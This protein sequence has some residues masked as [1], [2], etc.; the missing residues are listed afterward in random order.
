MGS[1][2][3][4][5][6]CG[7]GQSCRMH[8]RP[9]AGHP[10]HP[11]SDPPACPPTAPGRPLVPPLPPRPSRGDGHP[12][13][14]GARVVQEQGWGGLQA[15]LA[16]PALATC[17]NEAR[18][19]SR[20]RGPCL[21]GAEARG[22]GLGKGVCVQIPRSEAHQDPPGSPGTQEQTPAPAW[23][24]LALPRSLPAWLSPAVRDWKTVPG[25]PG[26]S[27]AARE[28]LWLCREW[29]AGRHGQ[30]HSVPT[31]QSRP[32][33]GPAGAPRTT[34]GM[35]TWGGTNRAPRDL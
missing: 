13:G 20:V 23:Q 15:A 26:G 5:P 32:P 31:G 35:G 33:P 21:P 28:L 17:T 25:F 1:Y 14:E 3:L 19:T 9:V 7:C 18:K 6:A 29:H 11:R 4:V 30:H 16:R 8:P 27:G 2:E 24:T 10:R 12:R 34:E 22:G